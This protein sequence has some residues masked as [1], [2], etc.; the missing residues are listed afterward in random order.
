MTGIREISTAATVMAAFVIGGTPVAAADP[1]GPSPDPLI[2]NVEEVGAIAGLTGLTAD[3]ALDVH[4]PGGNHQY[5]G[6][7]PAECHAVFDQDVAFAGAGPFRSVTYTGA[8]NRSITQAV[9]IWPS[10]IDA[11]AALK[12]LATSLLACSNDGVANM[13]FTLQVLDPTTMALCFS[14]CSTIYR[15]SG[16][17]LIAVNAER[18]GDSDRIATAVVQQVAARAKAL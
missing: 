18:F 8:A 6:Q 12:D 10:G 14:Q 3:P 13:S 1:A 11:K 5:D 9:G 4:R 15:V 17:A 2:L 7:Y 16:P